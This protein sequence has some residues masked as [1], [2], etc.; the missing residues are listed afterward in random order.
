MSAAVM[1][2]G[3]ATSSW[4]TMDEILGKAG[5]VVFHNEIPRNGR[6]SLQQ[7]FV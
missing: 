2:L 3:A 7:T 5:E 1:A 4:Q 6:Y